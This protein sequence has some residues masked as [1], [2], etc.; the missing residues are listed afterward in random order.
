MAL[1]GRPA[2]MLDV[3]SELATTARPVGIVVKTTRRVAVALTMAIGVGL[4]LLP[5]ERFAVRALP[6]RHHARLVGDDGLFTL[7][8][9]APETAALG[10]AMGSPSRGGR[11][12]HAGTTVLMHVLATPQ[13]APPFWEDHNWRT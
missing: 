10:R 11:R 9:V 4:L 2:G 8:G 6:P 5:L 3:M 1:S 12:R 13:G 7:R